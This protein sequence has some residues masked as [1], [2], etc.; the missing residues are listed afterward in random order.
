[1]VVKVARRG[2]SGDVSVVSVAAIAEAAG[3][4][5]RT[6]P[7][8]PRPGGV[9]MATMVSVVENTPTRCGYLRAEMYTVFENASPMLSVATPGTSATARCTMRRS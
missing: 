6:T 4:L 8:P 5:S 1:M 3:P 7:I 9:A 2:S